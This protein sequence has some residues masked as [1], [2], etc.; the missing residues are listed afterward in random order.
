MVNVIIKL[1]L[2]CNNVSS[3]YLKIANGNSNKMDYKESKEFVSFI[4]QGYLS[5]LKDLSWIMLL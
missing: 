5:S 1:M 3:N 4:R 2:V